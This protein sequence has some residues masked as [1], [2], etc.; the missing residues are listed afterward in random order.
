MWE[1]SET[2]IRNIQSQ[3]RG[4]Q[5]PGSFRPKQATPLTFPN[6]NLLV[7]PLTGERSTWLA[8]LQGPSTHYL[9][10]QGPNDDDLTS[11]VRAPQACSGNPVLETQ[12]HLTQR[13]GAVGWAAPQRG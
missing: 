3:P 4:T 2:E 7:V 1:K 13:P 11:P 9:W 8:R 12:E 5:D 10:R 6:T